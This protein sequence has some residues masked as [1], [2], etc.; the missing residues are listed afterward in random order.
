MSNGPSLSNR[1][2][3]HR[4]SRGWSQQKLADESGIARASV[5]AIEINRLV[6]SA[7]AAL[8]LAA[9]L[10]CRVEDLFQLAK[11]E[12]EPTCWAWPATS[13]R[14]WQAE[15]NGRTLLFPYEATAAGAIRHD[16][17]A[18]DGVLDSRI[19]APP[20]T[21]VM[22][23][24]DPAVGLL[25]EELARSANIR[26]L[27]F[28]RSSRQALALLKQGLVHVAGLHL[29]AAGEEGNVAAV[30]SELEGA[31]TMVRLV[32]WEEG[33]ATHRGR[34]T[35]I[36]SLVRAKTRWVGREVG[37]GARQ[38]LDEVLGRRPA[39]RRIARD[40]RGVADAVGSGWADAGVCL[41]LTAEEA[42]LQFLSVREEAY[43]LCFADRN[44]SDPRIRRLLEV[45]KSFEYRR[46][47]DD[48]PGY[49]ADEIGITSNVRCGHCAEP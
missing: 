1:V 17:I 12:S 46:L 40:H 18:R 41:R 43:D 34:K 6:P 37:S 10:N 33:I 15:V 23:C 49:R 16:G 35:S 14:Y 21:L 20:A 2:R 8:S 31:F 28:V 26:L 3:E 22:A 27:A 25:A 42:G 45:L 29:T 30:Q 24:C 47:I 38:C 9:A 36:N 4:Q 39:P 13:G 19:G 5:S 44:A 11:D 48:L 7:A 32:R